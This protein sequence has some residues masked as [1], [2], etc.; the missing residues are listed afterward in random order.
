MNSL[1]GFSLAM[2]EEV[3]ESALPQEGERIKVG[4]EKWLKVFPKKFEVLEF[5]VN[6]KL[7]GEEGE[8]G[9][10][11]A[12]VVTD[13]SLMKD[14]GM[15]VYGRAIGSTDEEFLKTLHLEMNRKK[16]AIHLCR[17]KVCTAALEE[18]IAHSGEV[19]VWKAKNVKGEYLKP[20]GSQVLKEILEKALGI[21]SGPASGEPKR[22]SGRAVRRPAASG[23][24]VVPAPNE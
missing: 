5:V 12:M 19:A 11:C 3:E 21:T 2:G 24:K 18:V 7:S 17:E 1:A 4:E 13:I 23:D 16:R 9:V 10:L 15:V 14:R 8:D 22:R 6:L 20:C